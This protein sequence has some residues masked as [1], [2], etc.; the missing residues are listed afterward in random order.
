MLDYHAAISRGE[1][2]SGMHE[3]APLRFAL[4]EDCLLVVHGET[5]LLKKGS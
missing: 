4:R 5:F 2:D 1:V 3:R